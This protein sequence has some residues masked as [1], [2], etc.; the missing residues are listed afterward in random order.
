M[1][2]AR[3]EFVLVQIDSWHT[4][5][6]LSWVTRSQV[7]SFR[8]TFRCIFVSARSRLRRS[9]WWCLCCFLLLRCLVLSCIVDPIG[10]IIIFFLAVV[11]GLNH[12]SVLLDYFEVRIEPVADSAIDVVLR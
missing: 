10:I 6:S 1:N 5:S 8:L 2:A 4:E 3:N 12:S 11:L 9:L 7:N